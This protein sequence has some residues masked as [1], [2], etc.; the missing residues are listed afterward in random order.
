VFLFKLRFWFLFKLRFVFLFKLGFLLL[1]PVGPGKL[2]LP[3]V[4]DILVVEKGE[5]LGGT[6]ALEG[7]EGEEVGRVLPHLV[8]EHGHLSFPLMFTRMFYT[9]IKSYCDHE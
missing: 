5:P 4:E 3:N 2:D 1:L 9:S 7:G 8:C 6:P